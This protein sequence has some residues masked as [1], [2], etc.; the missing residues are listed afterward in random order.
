MIVDTANQEPISRE[1]LED[2]WQKGHQTLQSLQ[3]PLGLTAS[4]KAGR[5]HALFGRD[6]LWSVLLALEAGSLLQSKTTNEQQAHALS[7]TYVAWL[8]QLSETVLRGLVHL[9]GKRVNDVNE[10]QPGR[11][12]HEYW[13]V[14]PERLIARR[15]PLVD[16]RY[17]GSF[18]ATF[19][20]VITVAKVFA[21]F[22]EQAF[23]EELWPSIEAALQWML[24]W[25]DLDQD[26]LVEYSRRNPNGL[27][28]LNQAWKDSAEAVWSKGLPVPASPIAWIEFQGY[29]WLAY[30]S[31]LQLAKQ[32]GSLTPSILREIQHRVKRLSQGQH[33][34][35][36]EDEHFPA[37]ALDGHKHPIRAVSSNPGHLL[38]CG[39]VDQD[40][41]NKIHQRLMLPD[42]FT[43][44]GL[45]TA[46]DRASFYN[47]LHYHSGSVWP[48]DNAVTVIGL[49][50]YGFDADARHI[51]R[52]VLQA[53]IAFGTPVEVYSVY[54]SH[55]IRSPRIM[56]EWV[57]ADY[58]YAS[59][60]QA[61]TAAAILY[62]TRIL[63]S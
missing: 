1:Q 7:E 32:R 38:W 39:S 63:M 27:G 45:R 3:S 48:F 2:L 29:A 55:W 30:Q 44:W 21:F 4:D 5:F 18:D 57:L 16:G 49:H 59:E 10:E 47:P 53:L 31:Y 24:E 25:S 56:Q 23:L 8:R 35:W 15:F 58:F 37:I 33:R 17:Y 36:L 60:M 20:Y 6:S 11:I 43:P 9:Q 28:L 12:I 40:E 26:G 51:A 42:M 52:A 50:R 34:F 62:L 19:L 54:P 14:V 22:E 46:S 13:E 61:W 41:A